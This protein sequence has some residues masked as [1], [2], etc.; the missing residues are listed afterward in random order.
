ME[1]C[2]ISQRGYSKLSFRTWVTINH[3]NYIRFLRIA[4][5]PFIHSH[6][7]SGCYW[8]WMD[9]ASAHYTNNTLTY[10]QQQGF[11]LKLY[12]QGCKPTMRCLASASSTFLAY[13]QKGFLRWRME[14]NFNPGSRESS[15]P[16][17]FPF[18]QSFST[19]SRCTWQFPLE[20]TIGQSMV[21]H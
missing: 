18:Q 11:I 16:S 13:A 10:L 12:P 2:N 6:H 3:H 7:G 9:L 20:M 1:H 15:R 17:K 5:I 8:L 19:Q 14:G 4:L 21:R